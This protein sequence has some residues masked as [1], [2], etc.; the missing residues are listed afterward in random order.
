MPLVVGPFTIN[1]GKDAWS[2]EGTFNRDVDTVADATL[3]DV[4][5]HQ[6]FTIGDVDVRFK[7]AADVKHQIEL[8]WPENTTGTAELSAFGIA[9]A[10]DEVGVRVRLVGQASASAAAKVPTGPVAVGFGAA[11]GGS[12]AYEHFNAYPASRRIVDVID[13]TIKSLRLPSQVRDERAIPAAKEVLTARFAGYLE[14]T[15]DVEWGA[16]LTNTRGLSAGEL[17]L[18]FQSRLALA[19]TAAARYR[20]GGD[21]EIH[22]CRAGSRARFVARKARESAFTFAADFKLVENFKTTGLPATANEFLGK[23]LGADVDRILRAIDRAQQFDTLDKVK[24]AAGD[25]AGDALADLAKPLIG[26]ALDATTTKEFLAA[27]REVT[28]QYTSLDE[29]VARLYQQNLGDLPGLQR[30]LDVLSKVEEPDALKYV[31]DARAWTVFRSLAGDRLYDALLNAQDFRQ[32]L[33]LVDATRD[34]LGNGSPRLKAAIDTLQQRCAFDTLIRRLHDLSSPEALAA[35]ADIQLRKLVSLLVGQAFDKIQGSIKP[36]FD[37]LQAALQAIGQFNARWY[38]YVLDAA[39]STF[40][41]TV[42][43]E[44]SRASSADALVD[45]EIDLERSDGPRLAGRAA[46]GDFTEVLASARTAGITLREGVLTHKAT[47]QAQIRVNVLGFEFD[48]ISRLIATS[49]DDFQQTD[50]GLL[51]VHTFEAKSELARKRRNEQTLTSFV[52]RGAAEAVTSS[53]DDMTRLHMVDTLRRISAG[54]EFDVDDSKTSTEELLEYLAFA[55]SLGLLSDRAALVNELR[56]ELPKGWNHVNVQYVVRYDPQAVAAVFLR[57][58]RDLQA[59][60]RAALTALVGKVLIVAGRPNDA[61]LGLAYQD[62]GVRRA[63]EAA[64]PAVPAD[65]IAVRLPAWVTRDKAR[66]DSL[67]TEQKALLQGLFNVESNYLKA[68]GRLDAVMDSLRANPAALRNPVATRDLDDVAT[69]FVSFA[70]DFPTDKRVNPFFGAFDALVLAT[71][72]RGRKSAM[73]LQITPNGAT[74]PV[75]KYLSA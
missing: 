45:V 49:K 28:G 52:L 40:K 70:D 21:F 51:L 69:D 43:A 7:A 46:V 26:K 23:L 16:T 11:G 54:Y 59:A 9:L 12:F 19:A 17:A 73:V 1:S 6:P 72:P 71:S 38:S 2:L 10:A 29:R 60:A 8:V 36:A 50:A 63:F 41:A 3:L 22:C 74:D 68:L 61:R 5:T 15:A 57:D 37:Q 67:P 13:D 14:L 30:A 34:F 35:V 24:A 32:V 58:T 42:N 66:V 27:L 18:D 20:L 44:F 64:R 47:R 55:E 53:T 25:W 39:N 31:S 33:G 75:T 48:R 65:S 4:A 62:E 56:T